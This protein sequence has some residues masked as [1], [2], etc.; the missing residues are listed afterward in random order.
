MGNV[1][2]VWISVKVPEDSAAGLYKGSIDINT[3]GQKTVS[4][5]IELT[6]SDWTLPDVKDYTPLTLLYQSPESLVRQHK[7]EMWSEK[8]WELIEESMKL[9]G[10]FGNCGLLIP[11]IAESCMGNTHSMVTWTKQ[12]DGTY[13][14][15]FKQFDRYIETAMKYHSTERIKLVSIN[16]WGYEN[17]LSKKGSAGPGSKVTVIN[18][19]GKKTNIKLPE[20]GTPECEAMWKPLLTGVHERLKKY[21]IEKK[22]MY[23]LGGDRMPSPK[24]AAMFNRIL[25]GTP[26]F[27][28]SHFAATSVRTDLKDKTKTVPVGM[29]SMVW[30]EGIPSPAE[31]RLYGWKY[32]PNNI[33]M[34]F[35]RNLKGFKHPWDF[36]MWME[37]TIAGG[38]N[39]NSRVGADYYNFGIRVKDIWNKETLAKA[40]YDQKRPPGCLFNIFPDSNVAQTSLGQSTTDLLGPA[41]DGPVTT[42]RFENARMGCQEAEARVAIEK[43]IL[44]KKLPPALAER[45]QTFLDNRTNMLRLWFTPGRTLGYAGWRA[46]NKML[47][48]L[49]GEVDKRVRE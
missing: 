26:W 25:P 13:T 23:G 7:V 27:R 21:K 10:E 37:C 34:N 46:S 5:P 2:P 15:D 24:Q 3:A 12:A 8:H 47:F 20:Y 14:Y 22:M 28:E 49:A 41:Q 39:G 42:I 40:S 4:V 45:C 35:K 11:L 16:V 17:A 48:D 18:G 9:M 31:K 1:Q 36:R 19:T 32:N 33:R 44:S 38:R 29:T 43:A 30:G 6:V